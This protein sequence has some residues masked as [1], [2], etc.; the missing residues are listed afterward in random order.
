MKGT[1]TLRVKACG[2]EQTLK[3]TNVYYAENV[4]HNLLSYGT[5]DV[6]GYSLAHRG[7][8]RVLA[9]KD[10]GHVVFDVDL[11]K[12]VLVVE[13]SVVKL[14]KAP[15]EV[16]MAALEEDAHGGN[17][18]SPDVQQG[19]L[20]DFHKRLGHLN[21]DSVERLARDPSSGIALTDHKPVNC[22][23]CAEGKQSKGRQ[24][25]KDSGLT[26]LLIALEG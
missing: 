7:G 26:R 9:A 17:E 20:L 10:G 16:I 13:G 15:A 2:K 14:Q 6:M 3:L 22:L 5:L 23:T 11:R 18:L 19:T 21:Y 4:V 1:L 24:S 12:K 8:R 25:Q